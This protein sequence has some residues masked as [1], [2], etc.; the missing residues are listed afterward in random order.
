[1]VC[2]FSSWSGHLCSL[3]LLPVH[4]HSSFSFCPTGVF[5][6]WKNTY[7]FLIAFHWVPYSLITVVVAIFPFL[8]F[9]WFLWPCAPPSPTSLITL[10]CFFSLL[11]L[12]N[13]DLYRVLSLKSFCFFFVFS[14]LISTVTFRMISLNLY[15]SV[16]IHSLS[17]RPVFS[18]A[19]FIRRVPTSVTGPLCHPRSKSQCWIWCLTFSFLPQRSSPIH[20][21]L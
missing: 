19:C 14:H 12:L 1:M 15:I 11:L 16:M 10:S 8:K 13:N 4:T 5:A 2:P 3:L 20:F 18:T 9:S 7:G 6:L 17:F 21:P